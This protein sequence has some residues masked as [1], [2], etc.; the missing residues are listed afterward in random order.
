M[1]ESIRKRGVATLLDPKTADLASM[2]AVEKMDEGHAKETKKQTGVCPSKRQADQLIR[3]NAEP[4]KGKLAKLKESEN[5]FLAEFVYAGTF[6][7]RMKFSIISFAIHDF[8]H[9]F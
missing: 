4:S 6:Q 1:A 8:V 3:T 7:V 9:N 5:P 2:F